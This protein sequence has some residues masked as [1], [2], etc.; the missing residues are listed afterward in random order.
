MDLKMQK[1]IKAL[2]KRID[3]VKK[4]FEVYVKDKTIPLEERWNLFVE[5]PDSLS[6][7]TDWIQH[8]KIENFNERDMYEDLSKSQ[9]VFA[10]DFV[11]R[12]IDGFTYENIL[13]SAQI[14]EI[15]N[16]LKEHFLSK[17]LK[18][19]QYDW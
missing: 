14:E 6:E 9:N 19:F 18:C 4:E 11:E 1:K 8:F 13:S 15:S 7:V 2:S 3:K 5:A 10:V 16:A 12:A 17:K